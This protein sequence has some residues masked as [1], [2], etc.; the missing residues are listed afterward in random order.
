MTTIYVLLE[1]DQIRYIGKTKKTDL[2]EKL[3]QHLDEAFCNPKKC[4]WIGNLFKEG[5]K[6]VIKPVFT[7][8]D[9]E[10]DY[11]DK[12]FISDYKFFSGLKLKNHEFFQPDLFVKRIEEIRSL[13]EK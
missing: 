8:E 9:H 12:L 11:Y 5:K 3:N 6:P 13:Q 2:N 4:E 7:Y 10:A 1:N